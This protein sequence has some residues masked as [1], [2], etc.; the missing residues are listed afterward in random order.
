MKT[1]SFQIQGN[2]TDQEKMVWAKISSMDLGPIKYK[3]MHEYDW[4][5][6]HVNEIEK[7]YKA[8]L[9]LCFKYGNEQPIVPSVSIDD[10]WH[11]HIL[12]TRKYAADCESTFGYFL[13]HFPYMGLRGEDDAKQLQSSFEKTKELYKEHFDGYYAINDCAKETCNQCSVSGC[14]GSNCNS[15]S[16]S[17]KFSNEVRPV[18]EYR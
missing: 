12:D 4:E 2:L 6:S 15:C 16:N 5:Y 1:N 9:F 10:F 8:Y 13:H 17:G 18:F 11:Q 3:L 7:Q 14:N